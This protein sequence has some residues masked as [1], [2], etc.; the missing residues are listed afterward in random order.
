MRSALWLLLFVSL[1]SACGAQAPAATVNP[2]AAASAPTATRPAL[3]ATSMPP[4][5]TGAAAT[6]IPTAPAT[7]I[8]TAAPPATELPGATSP[9]V[10]VSAPVSADNP[11]ATQ[12]DDNDPGAMPRFPVEPAQFFEP[13]PMHVIW[14]G[15]RIEYD[16]R[17]SVFIQEP[18][19][20]MH[21]DTPALAAAGLAD[22]VDRCRKEMWGTDCFN[23]RIGFAFYDRQGLGLR[24]WLAGPG[25][26]YDW[27]SPQL[28]PVFETTVL[29]RP[30]LAWH[31][32]GIMAAFITYV[33]AIDN[34]MLVVNGVTD[35]TIFQ[36]LSFPAPEPGLPAGGFA[37]VRAERPTDLW[38]SASG[39]ERV[40]E[41]PQLYVGSPVA[42]LERQGGAARVRTVDH[43]IGWIRE[44]DNALTADV[45]T[46]APQADFLAD[47]TLDGIV[48]HANPIPLRELPIS[49]APEY[50]EPL[51][52][53]T[54]FSIIGTSG[55]WLLVSAAG[56]RQGWMRW[57][58]DG[59]QYLGLAR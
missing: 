50:G 19:R 20:A 53:G 33:V 2:P 22:P 26:K 5:A 25:S 24:E 32:D 38:A 44:A 16:P 36:S 17:H 14:E 10:V 35:D 15:M 8:P 23:N 58:Y 43:V 31:S 57:H 45:R 47:W 40:S 11:P 41:R 55:D 42:I 21:D 39:G 1:L 34:R 56:N 37:M 9:P 59:A 7:E 52:P 29:G 28:D 49:T 13:G 51:P 48:T 18:V 27:W 46:I 54:R 3:P 4:P 12:P 6:P 30:A